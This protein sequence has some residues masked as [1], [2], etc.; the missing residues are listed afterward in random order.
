[1]GDKEIPFSHV[2]RIIIGGL[3]LL[4]IVKGIERLWNWMQS[5]RQTSQ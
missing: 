1:M 2:E 5:P 3:I 4:F